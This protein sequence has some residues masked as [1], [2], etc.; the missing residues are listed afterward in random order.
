MQTRAHASVLES[1]QFVKAL[2]IV[3]LG[4]ATGGIHIAPV[5]QPPSVL[6]RVKTLDSTG[7]LRRLAYRIHAGLPCAQ[8]VLRRERLFK[9]ALQII[10]CLEPDR[11][12]YQPLP[13]SRT[14]SRFR[15]ESA[16]GRTGRVRDRR[17]RIP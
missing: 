13:D 11:N 2:S 6:D 12:S 3:A 16:V 8:T 17:A 4:G 14:R 5:A 1:W 7:Q 15:G 9:I 10:K